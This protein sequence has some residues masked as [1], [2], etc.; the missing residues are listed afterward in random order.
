LMISKTEIAS[1]LWNSI[2]LTAI[3]FVSSHVAAIANITLN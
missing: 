1:G 2:R 3:D